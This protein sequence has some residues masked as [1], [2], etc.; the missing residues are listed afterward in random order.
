MR[1]ATISGSYMRSSDTAPYSPE[2]ND[3]FHEVRLAAEPQP[4]GVVA[5]N[6]ALAKYLHLNPELDSFPVYSF[7]P[8]ALRGGLSRATVVDAIKTGGR[9]FILN[10]QAAVTLGLPA[11]IYLNLAEL[12]WGE[13]QLELRPEIKGAGA[14]FALTKLD[15][16][17]LETILLDH[18]ALMGTYEAARSKPQPP[19][20]YSSLA[21]IDKRNVG[22]QNI[23]YGA[24]SVNVS[25]ALLGRCA[26]KFTPT[27]L[28]VEQ[29]EEFAS[30]LK[31]VSGAVPAG[32]EIYESRIACE[33]RFTAGSVRAV[34]FDNA[35]SDEQL[36]TLCE[37]VS[38]DELELEETLRAMIE[39]T[40]KYL[41]I[42][43]TTTTTTTT[44]SS[45]CAGD[46]GFSWVKI[47][48]ISLEFRPAV[49]KELS[50]SREYKNVKR[51]AWYLAKDE[52]VVR[53]IGKMFTDMESFRG[54]SSPYHARSEDE[55]WFQHELFALNVLR[56]H[57]R[58]CTQFELAT[59]LRKRLRVGQQDR[60]EIRESVVRAM[61]AAVNESPYAFLEVGKSTVN[62]SIRYPHL[63]NYTKTYRFIRSQMAERYVL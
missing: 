35:E 15:Q 14:A 59:R 41:E 51:S 11:C 6:S 27:W 32:E 3:C 13:G 55:L 40:R 21:I 4:H 38:T 61:I 8:A 30:Y 20:L 2:A 44:A 48:D 24:H 19:S 43:A 34:Y 54:G 9:T 22:G 36:C 26:I 42:M 56:D 50:A 49:G 63:G 28:C 58:V 5:R 33:I 12:G 25:M 17:K 46:G 23:K 7:F 18:P 60:L 1:P 39:D 47:G 52:I 57:N 62:V 45:S 53:K 31:L 37:R 16:L 29:S 10:E